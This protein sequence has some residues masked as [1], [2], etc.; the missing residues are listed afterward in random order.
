MESGPFSL[1]FPTESPGHSQLSYKTG[2]MSSVSSLKLYK[3]FNTLSGGDRNG[4]IYSIDPQSKMPWR[5]EV[6]MGSKRSDFRKHS[7][8][9]NNCPILIFLA[10]VRVGPR[11]WMFGGNESGDVI[12][13]FDIDSS[14]SFVIQ[15]KAKLFSGTIPYPGAPWMEFSDGAATIL[16]PQIFLN[17]QTIYQPIGQPAKLKK[18]RVHNRRIKNKRLE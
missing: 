17:P 11:V 7:D 6:R 12:E 15:V 14:G 10:I 8:K 2:F 16:L 9:R 4:M 13:R 3:L 1:N 5:F 18:R